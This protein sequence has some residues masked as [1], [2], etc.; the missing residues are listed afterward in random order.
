MSP[1]QPF[2]VWPIWRRTWY[3]TSMLQWRHGRSKDFSIFENQ[4]SHWQ[5]T[6]ELRQ[7]STEFVLDKCLKITF[8]LLFWEIMKHLK[9]FFRASLLLFL[10]F[11]IMRRQTRE[12]GSLNFTVFLM[13]LNCPGT[14]HQILLVFGSYSPKGVYY[15]ILTKQM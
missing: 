6:S 15:K 4:S 2:M 13:I 12:L 1:E 8:F 3:F 14:I 11:L 9:V 7:F 5:T 10:R